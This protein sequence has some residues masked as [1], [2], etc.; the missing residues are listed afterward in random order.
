[1]SPGLG[2]P[3]IRGVKKAFVKNL[4]EDKGHPPASRREKA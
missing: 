4:G 1:L 3:A 2:L